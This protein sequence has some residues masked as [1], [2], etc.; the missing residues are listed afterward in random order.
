MRHY[1]VMA[2]EAENT[3]NA[4][5]GGLQSDRDIMC[6]SPL[7]VYDV[8]LDGQIVY[9]DGVRLNE[10][11]TA[12]DQAKYRMQVVQQGGPFVMRLSLVRRESVEVDPLPT[13]KAVLAGIGRGDCRVGARSHRGFG[14]LAIDKARF[15]KFDFAED[16]GRQ[17]REWLDLD[18]HEPTAFTD[19]INEY[20]SI[21]KHE[22]D[23]FHRLAVPLKI[24]GTL[25]IR[26]YSVSFG[27]RQTPD[28]AQLQT[29]KTAV[30][31]GSTWM[32]ALRGRIASLVASMAEISWDEAQE[33]ISPFFGTWK[34]DAD[35]GLL[36]SPV[37]VEES[38]VAGGHALPTTRTSIDRFTGGVMSGRLYTEALWVGGDTELCL[39][40]PKSDKNS[41]SICGLLLWAIADLI[42][43]LLAVGGETAV[44]RGI[45]S[46]RGEVKLDGAAVFGED[47]LPNGAAEVYFRQAEEWSMKGGD[48][49]EGGREI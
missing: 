35:K 28:Y 15:R 40:W 44:G 3:I 13:L 32:G 7:T 16:K 17:F 19:C 21:L 27:D 5:F 25:M 26:S 6:Q 37:W 4:L 20:D 39:C 45:V 41:D 34:E 47:G 48:R 43:G 36:A 38:I 33:K 29:E 14:R 1:L 49:Y 12:A 8:P 30:I 9:R 22:S 31:P 23:P 10:R 46:P 11:K 2:G 18:F 24:E 42:H